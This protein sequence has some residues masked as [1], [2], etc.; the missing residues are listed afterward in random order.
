MTRINLVHVKEL[1]DQHLMAEYRELPRVFGAVQKHVQARKRVRDFKINS[2][3]LLGSGHVTFFYDK[4]LYL[5]KR[6]IDIVNEC[7][8]RGM[9]IQNTEVNDISSFPAEFCNDYVPSESEIKT[10]RERLIEKLQMKPKWYKFTDV[11]LTISTIQRTKTFYFRP[12]DGWKRGMNGDYRVLEDSLIERINSELQ[13]YEGVK[14]V[15]STSRYFEYYIES[16]T[17]NENS[18]FSVDNTDILRNAVGL[19]CNIAE[20][21]G[22]TI[23]TMSELE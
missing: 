13:K 3:Y 6:H 15:R 19:L 12:A 8:R 18:S 7:L 17:V 11:E 22:L 1:A 9:K 20:E 2:T 5:Q 4:L 21:M 23:S 10:S 16:S 14:V